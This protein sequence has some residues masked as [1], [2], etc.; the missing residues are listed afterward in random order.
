MKWNYFVENDGK[1][2]VVSDLYSSVW[3]ENRTGKKMQSRNGP[4]TE[5][6]NTVMVRV[7]VTV[8]VTVTEGITVLTFANYDV[9]RGG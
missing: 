5:E 8:T 9:I 1:F 3:N 4:Q 7:M 6:K 2:R